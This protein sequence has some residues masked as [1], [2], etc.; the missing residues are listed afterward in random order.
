MTILACIHVTGYFGAEA[1]NAEDVTDSNRDLLTPHPK[2]LNLLAATVG[3][4][5]ATRATLSLNK[6][7][8]LDMH[9]S[10]CFES[11]PHDGFIS[12]PLGAFWSDDCLR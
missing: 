1:E 6:V 4:S 10:S 11:P 2:W 8:H 5:K 12:I 3:F 9:L 7:L